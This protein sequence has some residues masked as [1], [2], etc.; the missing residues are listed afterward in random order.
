[1][2]NYLTVVFGERELRIGKLG[3]GVESA[4][5]VGIGTPNKSSKLTINQKSAAQHPPIY[6]L[7]KPWDENSVMRKTILERQMSLQASQGLVV[8]TTTKEPVGMESYIQGIIYI[9]IYIYMYLGPRDRGLDEDEF[10]NAKVRV[11]RKLELKILKRLP[12]LYKDAK[13]REI[14]DVYLSLEHI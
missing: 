4:E 6:K 9:Y 14:F 3:L 2:R 12:D 5:K 8:H 13:I 11:Q 10:D 1:M 7:G